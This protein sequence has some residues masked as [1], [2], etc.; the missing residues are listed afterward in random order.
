M[1]QL[2]DYKFITQMSK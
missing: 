1:V 2:G